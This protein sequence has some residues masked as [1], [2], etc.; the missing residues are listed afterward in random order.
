MADAGT[1]QLKGGGHTCHPIQ[2]TTALVE[3]TIVSGGDLTLC[4]CPSGCR[5]AASM[6]PKWQDGA[7]A[8]FFHPGTLSGF[9]T[10]TDRAVYT[11]T[12]FRTG[13]NPALQPQPLSLTHPL[14]MR[15]FRWAQQPGGSVALPPGLSSSAYHHP[16]PK[17]SFHLQPCISSFPCVC[18]S[19]MLMP[20]VRPATPIP[21]A[22]STRW[23]T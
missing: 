15:R 19:V 1:R 11:T 4:S 22:T 14:L 16:R 13:H 9:A 3:D 21:A 12:S 8:A 17:L 6:R 20:C 18:F 2:W 23:T 5:H 10:N 7:T